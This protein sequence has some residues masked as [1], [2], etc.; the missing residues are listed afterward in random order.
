VQRRFDTFAHQCNFGLQQINS[1]WV[2]SLDADY[3]LSNELLRELESLTPATDIA[4]YSAGFKYCMAGRPLRATLYPPRVVLYRRDN[5]H[6]RDDGHGHRVQLSGPIAT[7]HGSI[8]HDDRKPLDRWLS[9]QND[10]MIIESRHLLEA[11]LTELSLQDRIR[12]LIVLAPA[13][14]FF[15]TLLGR[16]LI[17]DGW[18]GWLYACQRTIAELILSIRLAERKW[19]D[20]G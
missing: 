6:Y 5:A 7:L 20:E 16:G 14:V 4:G 10:Y 11:S 2:L 9:D 18:R 13:L 19:Q 12:R 1:L 15:Y 8:Y 3:V 17:L